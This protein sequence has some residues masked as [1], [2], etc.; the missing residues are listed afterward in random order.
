M[1]DQEIRDLLTDVMGPP[2]TQDHCPTTRDCYQFNSLRI[3]RGTKQ[4]CIVSWRIV[5]DPLVV[6]QPLISQD[7]DRLRKILAEYRIQLID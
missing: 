2:G 3:V 6:L 7:K 1:T 5:G 4:F